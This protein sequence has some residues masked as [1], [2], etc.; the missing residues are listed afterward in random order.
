M[1]PILE[2]THQLARGNAR[3]DDLLQNKGQSE[4]CQRRIRHLGIS[5]E[6]ELALDT[7][8]Q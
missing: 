8:I 5:I 3:G 6:N 7:H 4:T 2:D 1:A